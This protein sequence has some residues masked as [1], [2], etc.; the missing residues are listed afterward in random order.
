MYGCNGISSGSITERRFTEVDFLSRGVWANRI[1]T[2]IDLL[3]KDKNTGIINTVSVNT[4][5]LVEADNTIKYS[6]GTAVTYDKEGNQVKKL[7]KTK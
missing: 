2:V 4:V 1:D 6:D 3:I 7:Q 5:L